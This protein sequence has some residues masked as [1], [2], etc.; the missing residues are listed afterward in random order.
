MNE[1]NTKIIENRKFSS[2]R[3]AQYWAWA[4]SF[5][6]KSAQ[7]GPLHLAR[8]NFEPGLKVGAKRLSFEPDFGLTI[9]PFLSLFDQKFLLGIPKILF[10]GNHTN[11]VNF[12]GPFDLRCWSDR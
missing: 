6:Q 3:W 8:P 11:N 1:I 10:S 2:R 12:S 7:T 5:D 4:Q 9:Q